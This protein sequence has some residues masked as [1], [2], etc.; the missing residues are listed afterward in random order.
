MG[1]IPNL[2]DDVVV[3]KI[4]SLNVVRRLDKD[5]VAF[6]M[7]KNAADAVIDSSDKYYEGLYFLLKQT[8][9]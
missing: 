7:L 4:I 2:F 5:G 3:Q 8:V 6:N 9:L 1:M